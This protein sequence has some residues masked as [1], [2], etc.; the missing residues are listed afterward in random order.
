ME[1]LRYVNPFRYIKILLMIRYIE[2]PIKNEIKAFEWYTKSANAGY[3]DGQCNLDDHG[4]GIDKNKTK[5]FQ[6]Y[7][8]SAISGSA[9]GQC[10]LG[11]CYDHG[12]GT[13]KNEIKHL[14]GGI[15]EAQNY[16]A[17]CYFGGI[18][19][20]K[21]IDRANYWYGKASDNGIK[22][23]KDKLANISSFLP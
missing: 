7:M 19:I 13:E 22:E 17:K 4:V 15:A 10:K 23:A 21:D 14:N 18:G 2:V 1:P 12:I 5:A 6:W 8:K 16:V 9:N 11:Y 3:A 20:Y